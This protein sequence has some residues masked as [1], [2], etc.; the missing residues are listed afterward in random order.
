V[1][2]D[3]CVFVSSVTCAHAQ[4]Y[5]TFIRANIFWSDEHLVLKK[6]ATAV[7]LFDSS[8][9]SSF[10]NQTLFHIFARAAHSEVALGDQGIAT[11]SGDEGRK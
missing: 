2:I 1:L 11:P 9:R 3:L 8:A 5:C 10:I 7:S 4:A 6:L